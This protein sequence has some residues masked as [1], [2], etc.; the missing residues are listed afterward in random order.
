[1]WITDL[2]I[3]SDM[4]KQS[5]IS[6]TILN[7]LTYMIGRNDCNIVMRYI[8]LACIK[9]NKKIQEQYKFHESVIKCTVWM[10]FLITGFLIIDGTKECLV[11]FTTLLE[12]VHW[13]TVPSNSTNFHY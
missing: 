12:L 4:K 8:Q 6:P 3:I 11:S 10:E 7:S 1:M 5:T 9:Q 2:N 13:N